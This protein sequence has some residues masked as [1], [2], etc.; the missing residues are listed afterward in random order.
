M[1]FTGFELG[2]SIAKW[3]PALSQLKAV[4][5]LYLHKFRMHAPLQ[6]GHDVLAFSLAASLIICKFI[7]SRCSKTCRP[8]LIT[9]E[10]EPNSLSHPNLS[11]QIYCKK[12]ILLMNA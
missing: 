12:K 4:I 10:E 11:Y 9:E 7:Q 8:L 2:I 6:T 5:K 1:S 3:N